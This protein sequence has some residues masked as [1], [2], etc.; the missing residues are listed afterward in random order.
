GGFVI[1][2]VSFGSSGTDTSGDSIQAQRYAADGTPA[3]A[4]FQVNTYTS[5]AQMLPAVAE[6]GAGGFVVTWMSL[7]S[8]G[9]DSS[10][11]SIQAQ[12]YAADGSPA[13]GEFQVNTYTTYGQYVPAVAPDGVDG[14]VVTWMSYGSSGTDTDLWSIQGR[15]FAS[16]GTPTRDQFQVNTHTFGDQLTP[17]IGPWG[18][19]GFVIAWT[20]SSSSGTDSSGDSIQA[21]RYFSGLFADGFESGDTSAW[22]NVVP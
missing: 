7:G 9:T 19:D 14:F 10:D 22:S 5:L 21:Q 13:G 6:D 15:Q 8:S 20:S 3:G 2:W 18:D 11:F 12:R 16:D 17:A 1:A 4:Q